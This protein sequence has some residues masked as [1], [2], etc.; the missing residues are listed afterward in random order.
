MDA[1][2]IAEVNIWPFWKAISLFLYELK[3]HLTGARNEEEK[4][5][6]NSLQ[7]NGGKV[8]LS[9]LQGAGMLMI[10]YLC[11]SLHSKLFEVSGRTLFP[12]ILNNISLKIIS[13]GTK[14][15]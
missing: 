15:S 3:V 9:F 14:G 4:K 5:T 13:D 7:S 8:P 11:G 12:P 6:F 1:S 10:G 2:N